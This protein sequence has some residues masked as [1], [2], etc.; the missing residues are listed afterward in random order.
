M[1]TEPWAPLSLTRELSA[2]RVSAAER[3]DGADEASDLGARERTGMQL[4]DERRGAA[5][6]VALPRRGAAGI[7]GEACHAHADLAGKVTFERDAA[8]RLVDDVERL[9]EPDRHRWTQ[10]EDE[11][12]G[13]LR[14]P[15]GQRVRARIVRR[16]AVANGTPVERKVPIQVDAATVY[17]RSGCDAV[18]I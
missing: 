2:V 5:Q 10:A 18:G 17:A 15:L 6:G 1:E 12:S 3:T 14:L 8:A 7:T 9:V 16:A 13:D 4:D 11:T